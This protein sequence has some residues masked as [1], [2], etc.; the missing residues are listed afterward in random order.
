MFWKNHLRPLLHFYFS[1]HVSMYFA[2]CV[3]LTF[4]SLVWNQK[5]NTTIYSIVKWITT[6]VIYCFLVSS[7]DDNLKFK[8]FQKVS[9]ESYESVGFL[10]DQSQGRVIL[11]RPTAILHSYFHRFAASGNS[12]DQSTQ[13]YLHNTSWQHMLAGPLYPMCMAAYHLK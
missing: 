6:G 4:L 1:I 3:S 12:C 7:I 13:P 11:W 9:S 5:R 2:L 10:I 8:R